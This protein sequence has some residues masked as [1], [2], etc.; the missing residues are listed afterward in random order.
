[1]KKYTFLALLF[2]SSRAFAWDVKVVDGVCE[3]LQ[4]ETYQVWNTTTSQNDTVVV[5]DTSPA[6]IVSELNAEGWKG[7]SR[8]DWLKKIQQRQSESYVEKRAREYP[9]TGA[10]LDAIWKIITNR[11]DAQ[12]GAVKQKISDVKA[13]HPKP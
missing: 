10:Q 5:V 13:K 11:E 8:T 9:A 6:T 12:S 2:I 7:A 1:M 4:C 3:C